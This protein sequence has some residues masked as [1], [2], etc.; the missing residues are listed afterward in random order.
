MD[1]P[2]DPPL[3]PPIDPRIVPQ[4]NA[5]WSILEPPFLPLNL[6]QEA[7]PA[8]DAKESER[9]MKLNFGSDISLG[10][11]LPSP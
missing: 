10:R 2:I 7:H 8:Y 1:P 3:D 11:T 4:A 5:S 6:V 9:G